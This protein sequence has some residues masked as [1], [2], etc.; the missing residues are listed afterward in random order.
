MK[1]INFNLD[2]LQAFVAVADKFS[3]RAAAESLFISQPAFSRRIEKLESELGVRLLERTTRRV[4]LT[5]AG[6]QFLQHARSALEELDSGVGNLT[7]EIKLRATRVTVA[8]VPSVAGNLLP[9]V[10]KEFCE[11]HS[12]VR[13]R[14]LDESAPEVLRCVLAGEADFGLNFIGVQEPDIQFEPIYSEQYVLAMRRD[15]AL[16]RKKMVRWGELVQETM[17][18]VASNSGNRTLIDQALS[19]L[20][21]RP[22][23][24]HE[25]NHV[26]GA[27]GMVQAG[28]G[29]AALPQ[30]S[31]LRD[32]HPTLIGV[33]LLEPTIS[34]TLGLIKRKGQK[35]NAPAQDLYALLTKVRERKRR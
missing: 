14:V 13:L 32:S 4:A 28:L 22:S 2:E 24:F 7:Q 18:A 21:Q 26:A 30:L 16:A 33:P 27:I 20:K 9:G 17:I 29:V 5:A 35:L 12:A 11:Q 25:A 19:G 31:L 8:C 23:V 6:K 15:H 1:R 3:F 34:R 10:L